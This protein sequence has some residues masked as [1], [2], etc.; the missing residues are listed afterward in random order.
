[1]TLLR[2]LLIGVAM[3]GLQI[4]R[5]ALARH[6][7]ETLPVTP[8]AGRYLPDAHEVGADWSDILRGG[9]APGPLLFLEGVKAVYGGPAGSR[10]VVYAWITQPGNEA[11]RR[12]W[13]ATVDFMASVQPRWGSVYT[14]SE[15]GDMAQLAAPAGCADAARA[16]GLDA[17]TRFPVG[18]TLCAAA[19]GAIVLTIVSGEYDGQEGYRAS[20]ALLVKALAGADA[21]EG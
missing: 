1:M 16:D 14:P 20:D 6:D 19:P 11:T 2:A 5:L 13:Q 15:E 21:E 7:G 8:Q 4:P 10:A 3:F 18:M 9:I 17:S 12:A